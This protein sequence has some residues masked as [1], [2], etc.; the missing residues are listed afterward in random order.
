MS[1]PDVGKRLLN[2]AQ[3]QTRPR[4]SGEDR[5]REDRCQILDLTFGH[6]ISCPHVYPS[7]PPESLGASH[8]NTTHEAPWV[9][10]P[11]NSLLWVLSASQAFPLQIAHDGQ[12]TRGFGITRVYG[13]RR[14]ALC[15]DRDD[16]IRTVKDSTMQFYRQPPDRSNRYEFYSALT[17]WPPE[18]RGD[19]RAGLKARNQGNFE[20]SERYLRRFSQ[21]LCL[22]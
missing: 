9:H 22:R 12:P 7:Q 11:A 15:W 14:S 16:S 8:P 10:N 2:G 20:L 6:V 21:L 1:S 3:R 17:M 19:L 18:V 5:A 4:K 13:L